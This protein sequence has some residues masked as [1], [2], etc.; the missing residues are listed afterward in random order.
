MFR[1][2]TRWSLGRLSCSKYV[3]DTKIELN[4]QWKK[5]VCVL[6]FL[7]T[8]I[9]MLLQSIVIDEVTCRTFK[10]DSQVAA[11]DRNYQHHI[12]YTVI[13]YIECDDSR[14]TRAWNCT[15]ARQL[16]DNLCGTCDN[17][18]D[19]LIHYE[20]A[21][22]WRFHCSLPVLNTFQA[23]RFMCQENSNPLFDAQIRRQRTRNKN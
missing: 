3:E 20:S 16:S 6:L 4:H 22:P 21:M 9:Q 2:T 15:V 8:S 11:A 23:V 17:S 1:T 7:I 13:W 18:I 14:N 10:A 19:L 5:K 12:D